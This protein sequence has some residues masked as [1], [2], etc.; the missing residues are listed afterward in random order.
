MHTSSTRFNERSLES[1][2][3]LT[4]WSNLSKYQQSPPQTV[5][6]QSKN[7]RDQELN[8]NRDEMIDHRKTKSLPDF[9]ATLDSPKSVLVNAFIRGKCSTENNADIPMMRSKDTVNQYLKNNCK[10]T[11]IEEHQTAEQ[12]SSCSSGSTLKT[13]QN[14]PAKSQRP[15]SLPPKPQIKF[16]RKTKSL[17]TPNGP[18]QGRN[19]K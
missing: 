14:S 12:V 19:K 7:Q 15:L 2:G 13:A 9:E 3:K 1:P 18:K 5:I 6:W 11:S 10:L 17:S 8:N 4:T 16:L